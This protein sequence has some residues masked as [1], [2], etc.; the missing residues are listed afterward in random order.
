MTSTGGRKKGG[1]DKTG[2]GKRAAVPT[3]HKRLYGKL[4][5]EGMEGDAGARRVGMGVG[6]EAATAVGRRK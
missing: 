3:T 1:E 6:E 4:G 2:G 5:M